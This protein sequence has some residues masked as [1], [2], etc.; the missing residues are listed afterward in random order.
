MVDGVY[1][2]RLVILPRRVPA[3]IP[4]LAAFLLPVP[5]SDLLWLMLLR[6]LITL[7]TLAPLRR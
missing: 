7:G 4:L 6:E 2:K 5:L 3:A 1:C